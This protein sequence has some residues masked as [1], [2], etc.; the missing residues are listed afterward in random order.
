MTKIQWFGNATYATRPPWVFE[1]R[2]LVAD[3]LGRFGRGGLVRLS[4]LQER[5]PGICGDGGEVVVDTFGFL[6]WSLGRGFLLLSDHRLSSPLLR[7][8][9]PGGTPRYRLKARLKAASD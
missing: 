4:K 7:R 2:D 6:P 1:R 9:D 3:D 5:G 8:T